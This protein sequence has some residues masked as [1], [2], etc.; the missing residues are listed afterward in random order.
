[1]TIYSC[2]LRISEGRNLRVGDVDS[3]RMLLHIRGKG[4][5]DRYVP[6]PDKT[7]AHLRLFWRS[8]RSPWWLF[9][10]TGRQAPGGGLPE[11]GRPIAD[12]TL[13]R[14]FKQA[15]GH[16]G[17]RKPAHV[18]TLRHSYAT[19]L[20]EAGVNLRLIQAILGHSTPSTTALYTHLTQQVRDSVKAPINDLVNQL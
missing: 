12:W 11:E 6:L 7:L 16:S 13:E 14:A 9:P 5:K 3:A 17:V 18:H 10:A 19:H 8:H 15:L 1:M 2:G 4:N 20:L